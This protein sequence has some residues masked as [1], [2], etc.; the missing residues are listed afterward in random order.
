M[1]IIATLLLNAKRQANGRRYSAMVKELFAAIAIKGGTAIAL[2]IS[3]NLCGPSLATIATTRRSTKL[4]LTPGIDE[5]NVHAIGALMLELCE[6]ADMVDP[7][8]VDYEV[9]VDET[10]ITPAVVMDP[11]CMFMIG[12]CG[13]HDDGTMEHVCSSAW[14]EVPDGEAGYA[15]LE[16]HS[17]YGVTSKC[18]IDCRVKSGLPLAD[19]VYIC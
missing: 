9:Q 12:A 16:R 10:V 17:R 2:F 8:T 14:V 7:T 18:K 3:A 5:S 1:I 15:I 13:C 11:T 4:V 6:K 19:D